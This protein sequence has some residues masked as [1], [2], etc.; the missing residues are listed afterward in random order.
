MQPAEPLGLIRV[1]N[2]GEDIRA[3][4]DLGVVKG[5]LAE[6]FTGLQVHYP[7]HHPGGAQIHGQAGGGRL[8]MRVEHI[9]ELPSA[10]CAKNHAF[11]GI[12]P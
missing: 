3:D 9:N 2:P 4:F 7:E 5:G 10:G 11:A 1:M 6:I 12:L 8:L